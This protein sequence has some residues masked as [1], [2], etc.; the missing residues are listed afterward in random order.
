MPS[1]KEDLPDTLER[2]ADKVQR[3]YKKTLDSAHKEY[4][5]EAR[6]HRVAWASVKDVADKKGDHWELKDKD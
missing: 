1:N 4:K 3:T 6:A 5:D 2:S